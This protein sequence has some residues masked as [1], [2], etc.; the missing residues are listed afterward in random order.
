MERVPCRCHQKPEKAQETKE[1]SPCARQEDCNIWERCLDGG[2]QGEPGPG[3]IGKL[4]FKNGQ[5]LR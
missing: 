3:E 4:A 2:R 5:K 1:H